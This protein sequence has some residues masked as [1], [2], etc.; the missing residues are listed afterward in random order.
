VGVFT[1]GKS[2]ITRLPPRRRGPVVS[3]LAV[4]CRLVSAQRCRV[5][6]YWIKRLSVFHRREPSAYATGHGVEVRLGVGVS[7]VRGPY[8][9][10]ARPRPHPDC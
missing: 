3:W 7:G 1:S 8:A 6:P 5:E 9:T 10:T 2:P 4:T